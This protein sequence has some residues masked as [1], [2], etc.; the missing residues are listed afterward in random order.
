MN[1]KIKNTIVLKGMASNVVDEAIVI[2]K[3]NIRIKKTQGI[4]EIKEKNNSKELIVK[5][6]EHIIFEYINRISQ[7][8]LENEKLRLKR[9]ITKHKIISLCF[10]ILLL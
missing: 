6:A 3:P 2:L 9:R 10:F 4:K 5:E 7:E 8:E 1:N